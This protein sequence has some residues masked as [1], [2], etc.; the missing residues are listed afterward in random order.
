MANE[1]IKRE[2]IAQRARDNS[3]NLSEQ[4]R[5]NIAREVETN[6]S[7]LANEQLTQQR[8]MLTNLANS[9]TLRSN[10]AKENISRQGLLNETVRLSNEATRNNMNYSLGQMTNLTQQRGQSLNYAVGMGNVKASIERNRLLDRQ[11]YLNAMLQKERNTLTSQQVDL[12]LRNLDELTRHNQV[13]EYINAFSTAL[14]G[15]MAVGRSFS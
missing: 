9:E 8:N 2:E 6:R 4:V 7:N 12:G 10:I 5:S 15:G 3:A 14:R 11:T 13:S 1:R